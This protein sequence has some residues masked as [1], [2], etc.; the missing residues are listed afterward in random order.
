MR[1]AHDLAEDMVSA[2]KTGS[3]SKRSAQSSKC[4]LE[5]DIV[6]GKASWLNDCM[7]MTREALILAWSFEVHFDYWLLRYE[8]FGQTFEGLQSGFYSGDSW[9]MGAMSP[10]EGRAQRGYFRSGEAP[11]KI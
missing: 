6:D 8:E 7:I 10:K 5:V 2:A 3:C 1:A 11:S 4:F 9:S